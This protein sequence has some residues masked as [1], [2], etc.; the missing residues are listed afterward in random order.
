MYN[1]K[2]NFLYNLCNSL[3]TVLLLPRHN[4]SKVCGQKNVTI[5][6]SISSYQHLSIDSW[7]QSYES[8]CP[9]TQG[10]IFLFYRVSYF[11]FPSTMYTFVLTYLL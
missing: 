10:N 8:I 6:V 7:S 1:F 5:T 3:S 4:V 9:K 11:K 2:T